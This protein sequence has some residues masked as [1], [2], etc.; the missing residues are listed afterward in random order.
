MSLGTLILVCLAALFF[1]G[2]V[3]LDRVNRK[4]RSQSSPTEV[5]AGSQVASTPVASI[6]Q[7]PQLLGAA[8]FPQPV[9]PKKNLRRNEAGTQLK[10]GT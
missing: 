10:H 9:R 5:T 3:V 2:I 8:K 1:G 7:E 6:N 4:Q